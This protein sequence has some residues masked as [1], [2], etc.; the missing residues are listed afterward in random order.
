M[1]IGLNNSPKTFKLLGIGHR[2]VGKTV[3]LAGSYTELHSSQKESLSQDVWFECQDHATQQNMGKLLGYIAKAGKY[4]PAT[5]KVTNFCFSAKSRSLWGDRTLCHFHW[6]DIPGEFCNMNDSDFQAMLLHSHGCCLFIDGEALAQD[7]NYLEENRAM[8]KQ[9]EAIASLTHQNGLKYPFALVLTKC[10]LMESGPLKILCIEEHLQ[11]LLTRLDSIN[12]IYRR[13]YSAIPIEMVDDTYQLYPKGT[14]IPLRWLISEFRKLNHVQSQQNLGAGIR[15]TLYN[16]PS[17]PTI[18]PSTSQSQLARLINRK[19]VLALGLIGISAVGISYA[20]RSGSNPAT[21]AQEQAESPDQ[22]IQLYKDVLSRE[23]NNTDALRKLVDLHTDLG[24]FN[25][26]IPLMD[27]LVQQQPTDL[28]LRFELAGLYAM[29]TQ[30]DKEEAVYDQILQQ[31][32]DNLLALT[33]KARLRIGQGDLKTA[34]QLFAQAENNAPNQEL[35]AKVREIANEALQDSP[36]S[37]QP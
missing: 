21:P 26:A 2:G 12:A 15:K 22:R 27:K 37:D 4:P 23:P 36:K 19:I 28:N 16:P 14:S 20:L 8:I 24:Q 30:Q 31:Q 35:K 3:F 5:M 17:Q 6:S 10:D 11:P 18:R 25:Q 7:P 32:S 9:V 13:F 29:N 1:R 34:K 33:S